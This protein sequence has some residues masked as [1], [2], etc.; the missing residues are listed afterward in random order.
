MYNVTSQISSA[1]P[2]M[3]YIDNVHVYKG[4][5]SFQFSWP[6]D[7]P[8]RTS[9]EI[10][11]PPSPTNMATGQDIQEIQHSCLMCACELEETSQ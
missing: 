9:I 10:P 5:Y 11:T 1:I 3:T 6:N 2:G 7:S 4:P 8:L